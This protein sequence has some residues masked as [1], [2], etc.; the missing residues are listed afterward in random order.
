MF[1][2]RSTLFGGCP[3]VLSITRAFASMNASKKRPYICDYY[4][5]SVDK[6][7]KIEAAVPS[8]EELIT[9]F[10]NQIA[11]EREPTCLSTG[12]TAEDFYPFTSAV[13]KKGLEEPYTLMAFYKNEL[14]AAS[15]GNR[16]KIDRS[17]VVKSEIR[18]DY[19]DTIDRLEEWIPSRKARRVVGPAY[20]LV[21]I[22]N[23]F[24]PK[25]VN[26]ILRLDLSGARCDFTGGNI[27]RKLLYEQAKIGLKNGLVWTDGQTTAKGTERAATVLGFKPVFAIPYDRMF[28]G[29]ERIHPKVPLCGGSTHLTLFLGQT[30]EI[31]SKSKC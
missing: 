21:D 9:E 30:S 26:E 2:V 17:R 4:I 18:E 7:V 22:V 19:K 25:D 14:V 3:R 11:A 23:N 8:D 10:L 6:V 15:I 1:F 13:A 28:D 20:D 29:K 5:Q 27:I 12:A 24:L 31:A 16:A